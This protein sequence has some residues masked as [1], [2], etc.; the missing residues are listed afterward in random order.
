[1]Q[2][3]IG[4]IISSFVLKPWDITPCS[5][6]KFD[7][8]FWELGHVEQSFDRCLLNAGFLLDLLF[9]SE[10]GGDIFL[11]NRSWVQWTTWNWIPEDVPSHTTFVQLFKLVICC[12]VDR[13]RSENNLICVS[14][15]GPIEMA[16]FVM[17]AQ[18]LAFRK[19]FWKYCL[20]NLFPNCCVGQGRW[21]KTEA[22]RSFFS[23]ITNRYL[24]WY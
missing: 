7:Q 24:L 17:K 18:G 12:L 16:E 22:F 2:W 13:D 14:G 8:D 1:M 4:G 5:P 3:D 11:L 19:G 10:E 15:P 21:L 23:R 6:L 9:N 20:H